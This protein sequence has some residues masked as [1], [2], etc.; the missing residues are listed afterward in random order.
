MNWLLTARALTFLIVL[1]FV[2]CN[3]EELEQFFLTL[4]TVLE[5]T[6]GAVAVG[7]INAAEHGHRHLERYIQIILAMVT[8][9]VTNGHYALAEALDNL[10][11]SLSSYFDT[12]GRMIDSSNPGTHDHDTAGTCFSQREKE[13]STGGR[14]RYQIG[15]ETLCS[16]KECGFSWAG[17]ARLYGVSE[18]TIRRRRDEFGI[19]SSYSDICDDGLDNEIKDI[20]Q[21]TPNAGESLVIGSLRGRGVL[22]QRK[23]VGERLIILDGLGRAVRKRYR[24]HRRVYNVEGPNFLWHVDSNHKLIKWR[25]VLHGAVDGYSRTVVYVKCCSNNKAATALQCF[26]DG[27]DVFG[28]PLRVRADKGVEN[29]DIA[30]FMVGTRGPGQGSFIAGK[31]VHNQRIE[32]MW[33]D[34]NR[35]VG[36]HYKALFEYLEHCNVLDS[37][38]EIFLSALHFIFIPR[39]NRSLT[40][41]Q[42]QWNHHPLRTMNN[43]CPFG[44]WQTGQHPQLST[45]LPMPHEMLMNYGIDYEGPVVAAHEMENQVI[46]PGFSIQLGDD[47]L[48][49]L[50]TTFEPLSDDGNHG[51]N[52]YLAVVEHIKQYVVD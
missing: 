24:I 27:V 7:D 38:D 1:N 19:A 4:K 11:V 34:I 33:G 44:L 10:T 2:A 3:K 21:L 17:I 12:L 31:S 43:E 20:L 42:S 29:W 18:S 15:M 25:F 16:L 46:V 36:R 32:R 5:K 51:I 13:V 9:L 48:H 6:D 47:L 39:I 26:M 49:F 30:R 22:V 37:L 14:P 45:V 40:E 28:T 50:H 52:M 41:F 35:V 23:R 8:L